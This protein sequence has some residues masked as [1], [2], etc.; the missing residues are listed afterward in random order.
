MGNITVIGTGF[1]EDQLTLGAIKAI[2]AADRV[3]LH[4]ERCGAAEYLKANGIEWTSLDRL[5]DEYEDFDEHAEAAAEAVEEAA[6]DGNV[7]YCVFDVRDLSAAYLARDGAKVIAGPGAEG[8]LMALAEGGVRLYSASDWEEMIPDAAVCTIV[9]EIDKYELA[10]EVKLKLSRA[11]PDDAR[12]VF[13]RGEDMREIKLYEMDRLEEYDHMCSVLVMGENDPEKK[14]ACSVEDLMRLARMGKE[15]AE[16]DFD[17]LCR[18]IARV[19]GAAAWAED[20]GDYDLSEIITTACMDLL[21]E[22]S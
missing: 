3:I 16:G 14:N 15:Y 7:A 20:R 22:N 8:A 19:A 11:Y 2:K 21:E 12:C 10:C 4:T 17:G 18:D 1:F 13:M 5:Y 9:R 6:Q